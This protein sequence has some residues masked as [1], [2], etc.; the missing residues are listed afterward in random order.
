[1]KQVSPMARAGQLAT[2]PELVRARGR[3]KCKQFREQA[4]VTRMYRLYHDDDPVGALVEAF[5]MEANAWNKNATAFYA[6]QMTLGRDRLPLL[7]WKEE[8]DMNSMTW[9]VEV[10]ENQKTRE[11]VV[12][13]PSGAAAKREAESLVCIAARIGKA[14][15]AEDVELQVREGRDV[16]RYGEAPTSSD[17]DE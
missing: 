10:K 5:P 6:H 2:D 7:V 8:K 14:T 1:M 13:A 12:I 9:R 3:K 11:I 4:T 15:R 16:E 17:E